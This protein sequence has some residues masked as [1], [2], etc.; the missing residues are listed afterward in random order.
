MPEGQKEEKG[1]CFRLKWK[2]RTHDV[3]MGADKTVGNL[4]ASACT[5]FSLASAKLAGLSRSR[6]LQDSALLSSLKLK[7]RPPRE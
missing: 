1:L 7:A 2:G 4:K 5:L 6:K 3:T